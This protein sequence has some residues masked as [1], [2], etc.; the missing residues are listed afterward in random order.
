MSREESA[1][2]VPSASADFPTTFA[3]ESLVDARLELHHAAQLPAIGA[4]KALLDSRDDDS[5]TTLLWSRPHAQWITEPLPG[6]GGLV[7]GLQP[8]E[9]WLTLGP[10]ED[11]AAEALELEGRTLAE[12]LAWL[13]ERL[14]DAGADAD[15]LGDAPRLDLH[16]ELPA[17]AVASGGAFGD[18]E[19]DRRAEIGRYFAATAVLL[20]GVR[21]RNESASI[22]RTW[23]H[24]FDMATL[25]THRP[26]EGERDA[27]TIGVGLTPGDETYAEPYLYVGPWPH[28][29]PEDLPILPIGHWHV[30]GFFSGV[31]T[32]SELAASDQGG[33]AEFVQSA[34]ER[35]RTLLDRS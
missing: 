19:R 17:H 32:A 8:A 5:H 3:P 33:P 13:R 7:A 16:Y 21:E 11:P 14:V 26:A 27:R 20:D 23:P 25:I 6:T 34:V 10:A 29:E 18:A 4:G 2:L 31:A 24:H 35:S 22:I 28:P 15:K 9:L 1:R 30:E 12:G